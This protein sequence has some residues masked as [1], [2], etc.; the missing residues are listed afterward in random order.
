MLIMGAVE[1]PEWLGKTKPGHDQSADKGPRSCFAARGARPCSGAEWAIGARSR[2]AA[3]R[4]FAEHMKVLYREQNQKNQYKE[5]QSQDTV[6]CEGDG[7]AHPLISAWAGLSE[8]EPRRRRNC[9]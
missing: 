6:Y 4:A 2:D 3:R 9:R 5:S 8:D 1:S 7:I